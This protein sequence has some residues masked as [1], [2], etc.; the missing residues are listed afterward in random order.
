LSTKHGIKAQEVDQEMSKFKIVGF[1]VGQ[2][3]PTADRIIMVPEWPPLYP[4]TKQTF[5]LDILK[6][7][8]AIHDAFYR[9]GSDSIS[10][11]RVDE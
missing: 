4:E 6:V 11:R 1:K 5:E 3:R 10:I 2:S 8:F 9:A 7:G